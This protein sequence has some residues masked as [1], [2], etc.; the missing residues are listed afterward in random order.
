MQLDA[1]KRGENA[2]LIKSSKHKKYAKSF[3]VRLNADYGK[4]NSETGYYILYILS[5][6]W[7]KV[8][9]YLTITPICETSPNC[10]ESH[11]LHRFRVENSRGLHNVMRLPN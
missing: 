6:I 5:T 10:A 11:G 7:P 3:T 4:T 1:F 9:G 2:L 8:C